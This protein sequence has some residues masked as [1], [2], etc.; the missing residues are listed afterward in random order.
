MVTLKLTRE[1]LELL[2]NRMDRID[3]PSDTLWGTTIGF[4]EVNIEL[5][6]VL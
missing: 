6:E 3:D 1:D 2:M 5:G 4:G